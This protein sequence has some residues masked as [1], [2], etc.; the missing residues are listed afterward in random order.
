MDSKVL[1]RNKKLAQVISLFHMTALISP[2]WI[3]FGTDKL[4]LSLTQSIILAYMP[5][6]VSAFF[7][8]PMGAFADKYGRKITIILGT[9]LT[10]FGDFTLVLFDNF[11]LLLLLQIFTG[12]GWAMRTGTLEGLLHDTYAAYGDKSSYSKLSGRMLTNQSISR[13]VTVPIG[14]YLYTMNID[15]E[16]TSYAYPFLAEIFCF[17][18]AIFA[19]AFLTEAR[20]YTGNKVIN[21]NDDLVKEKTSIFSHIIATSKEMLDNRDIVRVVGLLFI[22]AL[23]SEGNWALY[24]PYFRDRGIQVSETGWIY[25]AIFALMAVGAF[26]VS[27]IYQR[28]NVVWAM[29]FIIAIEA[30]GIILLHSFLPV[31]IVGFTVI[32]IINPMCFHL[33]DNAIQNRMRGDR[34]STALSIAS[35]GYTIGS[36]IGTVGVGAVA[37]KYGVLNAMWIFVAIGVLIFA[38]IGLYSYKDGLGVL[39]VDRVAS[40]DLAKEENASEID[41]TFESQDAITASEI[42]NAL[43]ESKKN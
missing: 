1:T 13:V 39:E 12:I 21:Y 27:R 41:L 33:H 19:M 10:A 29:N 9:A 22:F 16:L 6:G 28:I 11:A 7:E 17:A 26:F 23:I 34:K 38:F 3:I 8:I 43:I 5:L 2:V 14:A 35:M 20:S 4:N 15:G 25:S 18:I 31:A 30:I 40:I 42:E 36:V 32:A 24:Q 37:D